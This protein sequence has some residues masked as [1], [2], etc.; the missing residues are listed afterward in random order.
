MKVDIRGITKG[1]SYQ[2]QAGEG[3]LGYAFGYDV[4]CLGGGPCVEDAVSIERQASAFFFL[5]S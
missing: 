5:A 4:G 2:A 1:L 3:S